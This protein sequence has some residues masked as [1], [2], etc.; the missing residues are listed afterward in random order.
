[1]FGS[2]DGASGESNVVFSRLR[3]FG[4]LAAVVLVASSAIALEIAIADFW[5]PSLL[6]QSATRLAVWAGLVWM[7]TDV[8]K[9]EPLRATSRVF[10][11]CGL[12]LA[13]AVASVLGQIMNAL[14]S[15]WTS[16]GA[17]LL[18]SIECS[19]ALAALVSL[20]GFATGRWRSLWRAW[21]IALLLQLPPLVRAVYD[22]RFD[23]ADWR[24]SVERPVADFPLRY[25]AGYLVDNLLA[26][27]LLV[28]QSAVEIE[29]LLGAPSFRNPDGL[30]YRYTNSWTCSDQFVVF[31]ENGRAT[32]ASTWPCD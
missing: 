17:D 32:A 8:A 30:H 28:G 10:L 12:I 9:N 13:S 22:P 1:M 2:D 3:R 16:K 27:K 15:M 14:T 19:G 5:S 20:L 7:V 21:A 6:V 11:Y 4:P 29:R 24:A 23:G 31:I 18:A 26:S 25:R